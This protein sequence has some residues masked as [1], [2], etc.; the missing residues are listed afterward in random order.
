MAELNTGGKKATPRVDMTPMVDLMFLLVTFFILTTSISTPQAMDIVKPD[1]DDNNK[2][3][4]LELKASKT[5]TILLGKSDKVAWYMGEAGA[6]APTIESLSQVE[7][8]IIDNRKVA[9]AS[10]VKGDFVVLVKPTSGSNFKN[11]VDIMDEL[12][13]LKVKV[14]QIDDDNILDN[15]KAFMKEKGIL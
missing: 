3:N 5:M 15:E 8:A 14:R 6:S 1:K 11:F 7:K 2:D 12:E 9:D 10:G 4:K 13:I